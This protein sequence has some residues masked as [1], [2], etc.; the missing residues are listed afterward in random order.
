M[1]FDRLIACLHIVA[2]LYVTYFIVIKR[3]SAIGTGDSRSKQESSAA[4]MK[5]MSTIKMETPAALPTRLADVE[6]LWCEE[7][8]SCVSEIVSLLDFL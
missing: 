1:P 5:V 6:A 8:R 7:A 4:V 2:N 3:Q